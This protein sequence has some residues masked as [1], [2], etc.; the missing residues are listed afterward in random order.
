[1]TVHPNSIEA[2]KK[3]RGKLNGRKLQ[4]YNYLRNVNPATNNEISRALNIPINSITGRVKELREE[5]LV[6]CMRKS[7]WPNAQVKKIDPITNSKC[8]VWEAVG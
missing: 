4:I 6:T 8:S 3:K 2:L 1:M 7:D 5:G